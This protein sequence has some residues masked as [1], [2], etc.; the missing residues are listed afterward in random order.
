VS[1]QRV[2]ARAEG[3]NADLNVVALVFDDLSEVLKLTG[4]HGTAADLLEQD[5]LVDHH[6]HTQR[7]VTAQPCLAGQPGLQPWPDLHRADVR[8]ASFERGPGVVGGLQQAEDELRLV[9]AGAGGASLQA[10]EAQEVLGVDGGV[11]VIPL[12]LIGPGPD[13]V[14][15]SQLV[16][17]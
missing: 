3:H 15:L 2:G 5:G 8:R 16:G 11:V 7:G 9:V 14:Q 4:Q 13:R 12:A 6:R 17:G 1:D 10:E